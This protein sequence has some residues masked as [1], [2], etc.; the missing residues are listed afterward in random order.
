MG[1]HRHRELTLVA[2]LE[3]ERGNKQCRPLLGHFIGRGL[4]QGTCRLFIVDGAKVGNEGYPADLVIRRVLLFLQFARH[5]RSICK[6]GR[7][8]S[9]RV[10][11][12]RVFVS[13]GRREA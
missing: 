6:P 3:I 4:D 10:L 5:S 13:R 1:L 9:A 2:A 7:P 8:P 11:S 12:K